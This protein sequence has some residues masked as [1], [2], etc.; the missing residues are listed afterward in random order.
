MASCV[1]KWIKSLLWWSKLLLVRARCGYNN[2]RSINFIGFKCIQNQCFS[3][4]QPPSTCARRLKQL[5]HC[6]KYWTMNMKWHSIAV[7]CLLIWLNQFRPIEVIEHFLLAAC[8]AEF[9]GE[10]R[11]FLHSIRHNSFTTEQ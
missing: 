7:F 3:L 8:H 5:K 6:S 1:Q 11:H 2:H 4:K 10:S 9:I